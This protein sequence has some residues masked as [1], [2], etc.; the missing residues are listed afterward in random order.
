[1]SD[2]KN[3]NV[4]H[5]IFPKAIS[6]SLSVKLA[7]C[8]KHLLLFQFPC[9]RDEFGQTSKKKKKG[10]DKFPLCSQTDKVGL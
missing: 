8:G 1:M 3:V 7:R 4:W 5:P 6:V 10:G 2:L 9:C